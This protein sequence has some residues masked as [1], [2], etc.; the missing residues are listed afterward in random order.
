MP[1]F[2]FGQRMGSFFH[3]GPLGAAAHDLK[4]C[5]TYGQVASP[6]AALQESVMAQVGRTLAVCSGR[7]LG[8]NLNSRP[9]RDQKVA[10]KSTD[11]SLVPKKTAQLATPSSKYPHKCH[12]D[13]QKRNSKR[14]DDSPELESAN[15]NWTPVHDKSSCY[16][17][18]QCL[19]FN[20]GCN[21]S[22]ADRPQRINGVE[23][24]LRKGT[25]Q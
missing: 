13:P 6:R 24:R 7:V 3:R 19:F 10:P 1:D 14:R 18:M 25:A 20:A 17:V 22:H 9:R 23:E 21:C 12:H 5:T 15:V 8:S 2:G 4:L 11:H 16:K